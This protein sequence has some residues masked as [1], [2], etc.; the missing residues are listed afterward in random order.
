[1]ASEDVDTELEAS[2]RFVRVMIPGTND[3]IDIENTGFTAR[4]P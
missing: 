2:V 4:L 1:M 3:P